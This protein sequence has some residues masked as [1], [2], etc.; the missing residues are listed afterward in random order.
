MIDESSVKFHGHVLIKNLDT[1]EVLLDKRNAVDNENMSITIAKGLAG[2]PEGVI[3]EMDFGNG[4][5]TVSGTGVITYFPPN[6]TGPTANL[7]NETYSKVVN[8]NSPLNSNTADNNITTSHVTGTDYTDIII[9]CTLEYDEPPGQA[10]FDNADAT[11]TTFTFNEIGLRAFNLT[12]D[13]G[14]L[15]THVIFNPIMKALNVRLQ[16]IYTLRILLN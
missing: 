12:S 8:S 10:A 13:A 4:G 14:L 6:V 16:I 1:D 9:T 11:N 5:T 3:Q 7:Y 2:D 15:L